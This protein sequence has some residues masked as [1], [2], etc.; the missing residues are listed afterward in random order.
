MR[1]DVQ[2]NKEGITLEEF[3][4]NNEAL[5]S[6]MAVFA[7][8]IFFSK[9]LSPHFI[10]TILSF[11]IM[12]GLILISLEIWF[13]FPEQ[14]TWRLFCF[15]YV[16]LWS[17]V[18]IIFSWVYEYRAIWN[19]FLFVPI[20]IVFY[21]ANS[22]SVVQTL[23][24]FNITRNFFGINIDYKEKTRS[25]KIIRWFSILGGLLLSFFVGIWFS[26]GINIALDITK[27]NFPNM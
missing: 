13:K 27:L 6:S 18:G 16:L 10:A 22:N 19:M 1:K 7:T 8:I 5:L 26:F 15:R 23:G 25:Q 20:S 14:V 17:I 12:G 4:K 9:D 11:L 3:I 21:L 24:A 2:I